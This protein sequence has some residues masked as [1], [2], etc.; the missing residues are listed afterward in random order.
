MDLKSAL[1]E[2]YPDGALLERL[3]SVEAAEANVKTRES[4][5][6]RLR[7]VQALTGGGLVEAALCVASTAAALRARH[8]ATKAMKNYVSAIKSLIVHAGLR[9]DEEYGALFE[10]KLEAWQRQADAVSAELLSSAERELRVSWLD[11]WSKNE[12][13]WRAAEP[14]LASRTAAACHAVED[15]LASSLYA[16]HEPR[17]ADYW[18]VRIAR[19][20]E[21]HEAAV[22]ADEPAVLVLE[23]ASRE[24]EGASGG[25]AAATG[26]C[27]AL[28]TPRS[29]CM[30]VRKYKT[31]GSYGDFG[32]VLSPRTARLVEASL[33]QRPRAYLFD[34]SGGRP[35][36]SSNGW[37]K[38]HNGML[39]RWFGIGDLSNNDLRTAAATYYHQDLQTKGREKVARAQ[40]MGHD[41]QTAVEEYVSPARVG[42]D[43]VLRVVMS[44]PRERERP[45]RWVC[46]PEEEARA[47][48]WEV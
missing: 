5:R 10:A 27:G 39:R 8:G 26:T 1:G 14:Q 42:E 15:A 24:E 20:R 4:Y 46:V 41:A 18:R 7:S 17:R 37:T 30:V 28:E 9:E 34:A 6:A 48:G 32:F 45:V 19:T 40:R 25:E 22:A 13:L 2:R 11:V 12:E 47:R 23:E 36:E 29:W 35:Y 21:E 3:V 38:R 44:H 43:G 31:S 16:D 33:A